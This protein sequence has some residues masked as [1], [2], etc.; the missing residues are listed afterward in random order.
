MGR[1]LG[2]RRV[3]R[4][5]ILAAAA[6]LVGATTLAGA[7]PVRVSRVPASGWSTNGTVYATAIIGDTVYA[8]GTFTQV[9]SPNGTQTVARTNLAAFDRATGAVRTAFV[10]NTNDRV[11]ALAVDGSR[12]YV[13]GSF[14]T[15]GGVARAAPRRGGRGHGR[16]RSQLRRQHR[17]AHLCPDPERQSALRRW[18]LLGHRRRQSQPDR[19]RVAHDRSRRSRLR[20]DADQTVRSIAVSPDGTM[21]YAAGQFVTIGGG[22]RGYLAPLDGRTGAL[23]PVQFAS[24]PN[25]QM[26]SLDMSPTGDRLFAGGQ[27]N[28]VV[29]WDTTT[30]VRQWQHVAGG[31][32]QAVTYHQGNV[33]FGFHDH[34]A[35]DT[36]VR[37][38]AADASTG[39]L[40]DW[41]PTINSFFG[42]WAIAAAGDSIAVGGEFTDISG[43]PVQGVA[44]FNPNLADTT[45]PSSPTALTVTATT[46]SSIA[47]TWSPGTDNVAVA[48]YRILRDG[49]EVQYSSPTSFLDTGLA[50][51]TSY[52][53]AVET[54][55]TSGNRSAAAVLDT[56]T[57]RVLVAAEG[58]WR[59][60]DQGL[61]L[62]TAWRNP[63]FDDSAWASGDGEFGYGDGDE[64]TI[65]SFGPD[66]SN[67]YTTTYFR[68]HVTI[69]NPAEL[70]AVTAHLLRDD[71]AAVYVNGVEVIRSN[72][73][74]GEQTSTTR[75]LS[76]VG[77]P[78]EQTYFP[79]S[80]DP[81]RFVAGDNVIAVEV[82]Q[83]N[84]SSSDLSFDLALDATTHQAP[85][86][87]TNLHTTTVTATSATLEW[88]GS[89]AAAGGYRIYRDGVAVGTATSTSFVDSTL[90]GSTT[91]TYTVTAVDDRGVETAPSAPLVVSTVDATAPA[92]PTGLAASGV[93]W[94]RVDLTWNAATDNVGVV[95]YDVRRDGVVIGSSPTTTLADTTVAPLQ[96]YTYTVSARDA[97]G[98]SSSPSAQLVATTPPA[99]S[100]STAPS[101]PAA[102]RITSRTSTSIALSWNASTDNVAVSGYIVSRDGGDLAP[103]ATPGLVD[104]GLAP[105]TSHTY[106]VRAVD[107]SANPSA[108]SSPVSAATH[109]TTES[110]F[111][112][113][114]VWRYTQDGIDRGTAWK[115]FPYDDSTWAAGSGQLGYGDGDEATTM[116]NGGAVPV[117]PV[118]L[119]LPPAVFHRGR[120][121]G[122]RGRDPVGAARRRDRRVRERRRGVPGQH[123]DRR[124][125]RIDVRQHRAVRRRREPLRRLRDSGGT[126]RGGDERHRDLG[127][128]QQPVRQRRPELRRSPEPAVLTAHHGRRPAG[129]GPQM[130][131]PARS[132]PVRPDR[133]RRSVQQRVPRAPHGARSTSAG[134]SRRSPPMRSARAAP[135][136]RT[137]RWPWMRAHPDG[138][139]SNSG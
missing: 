35:G 58:T 48:G 34:F 96:S 125:H 50:G 90:A 21:A 62:G 31:D 43:V 119:A 113:A 8:G 88:T 71:G 85:P 11:R 13:G 100:D 70:G 36:T 9:R 87:P 111:D 45:P 16:G 93:Q 20:P 23:L 4:G 55:D 104:S 12:L 59:Y 49:V 83:V 128:Q 136:A 18:F 29:S 80:V 102:L 78:D 22:A 99:P 134:A 40:E 106:R 73:R 68:S 127:P 86:A 133:P 24:A 67:R 19:G 84:L 56:G 2:A 1:H 39:A 126:A 129:P 122:C 105:G 46:G 14:T 92:P 74:D 51:G 52:R 77:R 25:D 120:C 26:Y 124:D 110:V 65:V 75:A 94:D 121:R 118:H 17:V 116:F 60:S 135:P 44:V 10:A 33:F 15:I 98:N 108:L 114:S 47:L 117:H 115:E 53:Y 97:A 107:A 38:L 79:F 3:R 103:T 123:A 66:P 30:G 81:A 138:S 91:Y 61:D 64:T 7:A 89:A 112:I 130:P 131:R 72:L 132:A 41:R 54:V 101:V 6:V 37:L 57:D 42:V 32:V 63:G 95:A 76:T 139:D 69:A 82:H 137:L 27:N 109:A 5:L 28:R